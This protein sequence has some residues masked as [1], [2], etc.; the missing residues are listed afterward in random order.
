MLVM[1]LGPIAFLFVCFPGIARWKQK[2][3]IWKTK[4]RDLVFLFSRTRLNRGMLHQAASGAQG[5]TLEPPQC[6]AARGGE[7]VL[8][9]FR[10][11]A[12]NPS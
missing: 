8:Y 1:V 3:D 2:N 9:R 11:S 6:G 7:L 4:K 12:D 5:A 10:P